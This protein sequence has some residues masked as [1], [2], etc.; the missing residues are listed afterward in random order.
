[1]RVKNK[2]DGNANTEIC[3]HNTIA[4]DLSDSV[5][6]VKTKLKNII[7]TIECHHVDDAWYPLNFDIQTYNT[8]LLKR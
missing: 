5:S 3:S 1:M 6:M 4:Y 8:L 2:N 7:L